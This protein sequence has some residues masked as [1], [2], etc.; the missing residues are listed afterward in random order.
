MAADLNLT[1]VPKW[2]LASIANSTFGS[3]IRS[4]LNLSL[5]KK[6][7]A[8]SMAQQT[9]PSLLFWVLQSSSAPSLQVTTPRA[10]HAC[11]HPR[12]SDHSSAAEETLAV[13]RRRIVD[14]NELHEARG[15]RACCSVFW[16]GDSKKPH[17]HKR[18]WSW[19]LPTKH[20]GGFPMIPGGIHQIP[21]HGPNGGTVNH[22]IYNC[23]VLAFCIHHVIEFGGFA[24]VLEI[25]MYQTM[26]VWM[27]RETL[28][29]I[30][31]ILSSINMIQLGIDSVKN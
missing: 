29:Y 16:M 28:I 24:C 12:H 8:L 20:Q 19:F 2:A 27:S 15:T 7:S 18:S 21:L 3:S 6:P 26:S 17:I 1:C 30:S 9:R 11:I 4:C 31:R 22:K 25:I 13:W 14:G 10:G 5:E 23:F